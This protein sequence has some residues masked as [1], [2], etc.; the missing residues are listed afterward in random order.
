M[1]PTAGRAGVKLACVVGARPNFMKAAP[2]IRE[3]RAYPDIVPI[4]IHTGQHYDLSMA[5]RFFQDLELPTP[6]VSLNVGSGSH[7]QQTADVMKRLEPAFAEQ[8]PDMVVVVG[9]VNSTMAAALTAVKMHIPVAHV[10][11]GLRSFDR[12]MPEEINRIVT[13]AIADYLF[14]TEDSGRDNLLR[15]G[16][17]AGRIYLVGNVMI[18]SLEQYRPLWQAS[19]VH[20]RLSVAP[21]TYGVVTLHRPSNVDDGPVLERL[22]TALRDV[23]AA[24]PLI[25]PVH[26]RTRL[27]LESMNGATISACGTNADRTRSALRLIEPLGYFD[28][29]ALVARARIVL[30]DSGG[31]QEETTALGVP[32]LTLRE[33]TERPITVTCGT[34]H[35][36]GT[37]PE[38]IVAQARRVL[39]GGGRAASRPYLWDGK[40]SQRIVRVLHGVLAASR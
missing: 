34:N 13:D 32:C 11:S 19:P 9:D 29:L 38:K 6:D 10:E 23:S 30:T 5:G 24:I 35:V 14:A 12:T 18:D 1:C 33:Q 21:G 17:D 26:P 27:R 2:L 28:F 31:L 7:A 22:I 36:V 25:F 37:T 15:E 16:V 3:M 39:D 4:L 8:R 20:E 40:A